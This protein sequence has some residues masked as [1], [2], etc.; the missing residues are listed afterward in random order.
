MN[1][2]F[3]LVRSFA[4]IAVVSELAKGHRTVASASNSAGASN[5]SGTIKKPRKL[6]LIFGSM[7][8]ALFA[9]QAFALPAG[10]SFVDS[11]AGT[12][13]TSGSTM[14]INST[15]AS[16]GYGT[17]NAV[18]DWSGGFNVASGQTV[19]FTSSNGA[20]NNVI[21]I[22][23]S[24]A[25]STIAGTITSS[26]GI[27]VV[28]INPDGM[29]IDG[30][31]S[32]PTFVGAS[33]NYDATTGDITLTN[34]PISVTGAPTFNDAGAT[35]PNSNMGINAL[36]TDT[37]SAVL[38]YS[39]TIQQ[40]LAVE[41][42]TAGNTDIAL[43]YPAYNNLNATM[44]DYNTITVS[45]GAAAQSVT[46]LAAPNDP[47]TGT[48]T[49]GNADQMTFN[50]GGATTSGQNI[51]TVSLSTEG[52]GSVVANIA[53]GDS[54]SLSVSDGALSGST[55][56]TLINVSGSNPGLQIENY[57]GLNGQV[58]IAG[59]ASLDGY[60]ETGTN[61]LDFS[62]ASAS[63][64]TIGDG[65]MY[66]VGVP[67]DM[68][69][70]GSANPD[71]ILGGSSGLQDQESASTNSLF[72]FANW[73]ISASSAAS[74]FG[75]IVSVGS[76]NYAGNLTVENLA[77]NTVQLVT[78]SGAGDNVTAD[79]NI[80]YGM[81][82][83][84]LVASDASGGPTA[85]ITANGN[86][87][88]NG[89]LYLQNTATTTIYSASGGSVTADNNY[90]KGTGTMTVWGAGNTG[91]AVNLSGDHVDTA[92]GNANVFSGNGVDILHFTGDLSINANGGV[93]VSGVNGN[94]QSQDN[95]ITGTGEVLTGNSSVE[96][97]NGGAT[98]TEGTGNVTAGN[99]SGGLSIDEQSAGANTITID[100]PVSGAN[101][102]IIQG[103]N[104][105][106][107]DTAAQIINVD[108]NVTGTYSGSGYTGTDGLVNIQ[109][110]YGTINEA[111]G[112]TIA[113]QTSAGGESGTGTT[114]VDSSSVKYGS[115]A[116]DTA[117]NNDTSS[118]SSQIT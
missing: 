94:L 53:G 64:L 79:N 5:A 87:V 13:G 75:D 24:G 47:N 83:T 92:G 80:V 105:P 98:I 46:L 19:D 26:S 44:Y 78:Q 68:L 70:T 63:S 17:G 113:A 60:S 45:A 18:I 43:T 101:V 118:S 9:G 31:A 48:Q 15:T 27:S 82:V 25:A 111:S 99:V 37:A 76:Q 55:N 69:A 2:I 59:A 3:K 11:S 34:A 20:V 29:T 102:S 57:T 6:T 4:G 38:P 103:F 106:S 8:C 7:V 14:T 21:N 56:S 10:G 54:G 97:V 104:D 86:T 116:S 90:V 22:D 77:A 39:D 109:S 30:T 65:G 23:D 88:G 32:L 12:F 61:L 28:L 67:Q 100:N 108:A 89:G 33:G 91:P 72:D 35:S 52:D 36:L 115:G 1:K 110:A 73:N 71:I 84:T 51:G 49:S 16:T 41:A 66:L 117:T 81:D 107:G 95:L 112:V 114:Y 74:G 50:A 96:G 62:S 85:S 93:I 42:A 40:N 58:N